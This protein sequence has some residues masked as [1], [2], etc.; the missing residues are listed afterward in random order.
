MKRIRQVCVV[1]AAL[2]VCLIAGRSEAGGIAA[3]DRDVKPLGVGD[4]IPDAE[5]RSLDGESA[6]L[7]DRLDSKKAILIVFRGGWCP[8]CSAHLAGLQG[9]YPKLRELGYSVYAVAPD[10][11]ESV[12]T[13]RDEKDLGYELLLDPKMEAIQ[14]LGLAFKV[15]QA[16]LDRYQDYGITLLSPPGSTDKVLPVPA[17]YLVSEKGRIEYAH[18]EADYKKRLNPEE[19]LAVAEGKLFARPVEYLDEDQMLKGYIAY[20]PSNTEKRPCVVVVHEWYGLNDYSKRRARQLAGMGYVAFAAD[21]YGNGMVAAGREQAAK[22]AGQVRSD[23][24]LMRRR[25]AAALAV[26]KADPRVDPGRIAAIGYCFGGGCVLELARS[27]AALAGV[28]SFHGNLDTPHPEATE[29]PKAAILVCH[30]AADP[31]VPPESLNAFVREMNR[32]AADWQLNMYGGAVH[33]FTNPD[34]GVDPSKG[35]AY[36]AEADRRSWNDM[37]AFFARVFRQPEQK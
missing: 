3:S 19:V 36:N 9:V 28:V 8:F 25:A 30:G 26:L 22:L 13:M 7:R 12:K 31:H 1:V 34:S 4:Q 15:S 14:A 18:W 23:R 35:A 33:A 27:G 24:A 2:G 17:V 32:C 16:T 29:K 20:D 5:I 6:R 37:L 21:M 11:T 10:T